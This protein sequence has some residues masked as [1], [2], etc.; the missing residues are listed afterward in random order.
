MLKLPIRPGAF[1]FFSL[2]ANLT[3]QKYSLAK[4]YH[5]GRILLVKTFYWFS[6]CI[7]EILKKKAITLFNYVIA[8]NIARTTGWTFLGLTK[9][10]FDCKKTN[11]S[12]YKKHLASINNFLVAVDLQQKNSGNSSHL[13]ILCGNVGRCNRLW[14]SR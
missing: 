2:R 5:C 8:I 6:F 11:E 3:N 10:L 13:N 12:A 4:K 9:T 1:N 14:K 7:K